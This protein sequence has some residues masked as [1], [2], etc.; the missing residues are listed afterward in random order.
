MILKG[1]L[2]GFGI[3]IVGLISYSFILIGLQ[4]HKLSQAVKAGATVQGGGNW[5]IR[6]LV[7]VPNL[8]IAFFISLAIGVWVMQHFQKGN[9]RSDSQISYR[10]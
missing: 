4:A 9:Q 6:G 3:F 10:A 1:T 7:H 8:W 2:L 5:D